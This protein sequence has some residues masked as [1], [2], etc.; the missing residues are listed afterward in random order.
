VEA[1]VSPN[2]IVSSEVAKHLPLGVPNKPASL[3]NKTQ[4]HRLLHSAL[5]EVSRLRSR[6][7]PSL[8]EL[9]EAPGDLDSHRLNKLIFLEARVSLSLLLD[10]QPFRTLRHLGVS[11]NN[12]RLRVLLVKLVE[13]CFLKAKLQRNL[14]LQP[15]LL[16][17]REFSLNHNSN[18]I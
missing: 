1:L 14:D 16:E 12:S 9:Q 6:L 4:L 17:V 11:N 7:Q 15:H 18:R 8:G 10:L 3:A 5:V 13:V 2:K